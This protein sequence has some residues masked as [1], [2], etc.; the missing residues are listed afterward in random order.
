MARSAREHGAQRV[1]ARGSYRCGTGPM[2]KLT[3]P[4]TDEVRQIR[5]QR[6]ALDS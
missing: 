1:R 5:R 4:A 2:T 3:M 6:G